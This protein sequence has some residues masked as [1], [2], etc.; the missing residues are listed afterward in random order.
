MPLSDSRIDQYTRDTLQ[1][2]QRGTVATWLTETRKLW[3]FRVVLFFIDIGFALTKIR[4]FWVKLVR[5]KDEGFEDLLQ[6]Q[7]NQMAREEF[8]MEL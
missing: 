8:G 2:S 6:Q 4:Q 3:T 1:L 7:F 5:G